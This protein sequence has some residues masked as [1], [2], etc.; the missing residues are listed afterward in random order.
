MVEDADGDGSLYGMDEP[1]LTAAERDGWTN[2][3]DDKSTTCGYGA[4]DPETKRQNPRLTN[5]SRTDGAV[6]DESDSRGKSG[7]LDK[8]LLNTHTHT[9]RRSSNGGCTEK[10]ASRTSRTTSHGREIHDVLA[11]EMPGGPNGLEF[12][13]IEEVQ[14]ESAGVRRFNPDPRVADYESGAVLF[15]AWVG[16]WHFLT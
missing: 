9:A 1:E 15:S 3:R 2:G 7:L 5:L 14:S 16:G 8:Q 10:R 6:V 11:L 12:A 4:S 13:P